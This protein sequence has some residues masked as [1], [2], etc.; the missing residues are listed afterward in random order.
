M[1]YF[2]INLYKIKFREYFI[3]YNSINLINLILKGQ[4]KGSP[5]EIFFMFVVICGVIDMVY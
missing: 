2:N 4:S 5:K 3:I 1:I